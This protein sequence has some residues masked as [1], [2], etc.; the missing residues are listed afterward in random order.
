MPP[1]EGR[2][3]LAR[4][5]SLGVSVVV[6]AA[7]V[8]EEEEASDAR[9]READAAMMAEGDNLPFSCTDA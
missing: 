9:R 8:E 2:A 3:R 6:V 1:K 5:L 4:N 7:V